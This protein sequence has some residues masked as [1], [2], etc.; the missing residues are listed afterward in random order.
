M[1][2]GRRTS[3]TNVMSARRGLPPNQPFTNTDLKIIPYFREV[4]PMLGLED[5][6][7]II[8]C[9]LFLLELAFDVMR[10]NA[11]KRTRKQI[12][13][14]MMKQKTFLLQNTRVRHP[15]YKHGGRSTTSS[16]RIRLRQS[17]RNLT[18][19]CLTGG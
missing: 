18:A 1:K 6:C 3:H 5:G 2:T 15:K 10:K 19:V 12:T 14:E 16:R 13:M 8:A 9:F 11:Y 7:A 4:L 17:R